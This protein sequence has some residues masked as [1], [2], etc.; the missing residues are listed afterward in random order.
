MLLDRDGVINR[1]RGEYTYRK[2]DLEFN[3][4]LFVAL[5]Q[6]KELGFKF[7]IIT[8]QGGIA[9]GLYTLH[10]VLELHQFALKSLSENGIKIDEVFICPHHD[11]YGKCL[12]RKPQSLLFE[13]AISKYNI[14]V[15]N[16]YMIGDKERDVIP[17]KSLGMNTFVIP[18]NTS[19]LPIV[20]KIR[21]NIGK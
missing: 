14:D 9:K 11:D 19:L 5:Q 18:Q 12:C 7:A 8:N 10:D 21:L 15:A 13:K 16:S 3:S 4:D 17:A 2:E 1:E 6:L 20:E